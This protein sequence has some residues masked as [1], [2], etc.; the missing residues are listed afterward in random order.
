MDDTHG[1]GV[2]VG[3]VFEA[4]AERICNASAKVETVD[5]FIVLPR[6]DTGTDLRLGA[7]E[8]TGKPLTVVT[9]DF[10][11]VGICSCTT[12]NGTRKNP[13]MAVMYG[14]FPAGFELYR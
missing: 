6:H 2:V 9:V 14:P 11:F 3:G 8:T 13:W 1:I 4:H 12:G 5:G 10:D 7:P